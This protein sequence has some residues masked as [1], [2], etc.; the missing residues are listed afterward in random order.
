MKTINKIVV[1]IFLVTSFGILLYLL[2]VHDL[3]E[4]EAFV[5]IFG[6]YNTV[7]QSS[8]WNNMNLGKQEVDSFWEKRT[9]IVSKVLFQTYE[10]NGNK[11]IILLTRTV[12]IG[13]TFECHACLPLL[14]ATVFIRNKG[15][16]NIESQ[17]RFLMYGGEYAISPQAKLIS[18]GNNKHGLLLEFEHWGGGAN[19]EIVILIPYKKSI[20]NAY[21]ETIDYDNFSDCGWSI[22]CAAYTAKF[23]FNKSTK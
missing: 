20:T 5:M 16:W 21:Q 6:N 1:S 14:S 2:S 15:K 22:Q 17:N 10:E 7:H 23:E 3:S 19:K 13:I 12:P 18:V 8:I 9:G 4:Q 11:K